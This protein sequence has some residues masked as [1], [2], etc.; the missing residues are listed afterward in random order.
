MIPEYS[1]IE[2][3][4]RYSRQPERHWEKW[5]VGLTD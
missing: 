1:K 4:K 2:G 3:E 5:T